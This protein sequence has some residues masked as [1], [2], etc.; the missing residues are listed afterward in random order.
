MKICGCRTCNVGR[1]LRPATRR[2]TMREQKAL[3]ELYMRM[4]CAEDD[5]EWMNFKAQNGQDVMING[6]RYTPK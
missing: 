3:D 4:C 1:I 2:M 5:I 6:I